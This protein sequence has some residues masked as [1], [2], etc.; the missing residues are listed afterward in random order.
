[1]KKR[2]GFLLY[3][4][5]QILDATGPA[6]VFEIGGM[7]SDIAYENTLLSVEGGPVRSSSGIVLETDKMDANQAFDTLIVVGS[8]YYRDYFKGEAIA[9]Y[10]RRQAPRTRR[11]CSVCTGAFFLARAG[12][13]SGRRVTTHWQD[14]DHLREHAHDTEVERDVVYVRDGQIWTSGGITAGIDMSLALLAEDTDETISRGVAQT[15]VLYYHRPGGEKQLSSLV[16]LGSGSDRFSLLLGW[17]RANLSTEL[18]I[19]T[20]AAHAGMSPRNFSRS[21]KTETGMSPA[22]AVE[23]LRVEAARERILNA[24]MSIEAIAAETG[25]ADPER[26]RRAFNRIYGMSP[27]QMRHSFS[28]PKRRFD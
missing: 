20:L 1:M 15:M 11:L 18:S 7:M 2:I 9:E 17:I 4:E 13:L 3:P 27:Q 22:K 12:I 23:T 6:T 5:F 24:H 14:I 25:F 10:L 8:A 21:F 26:L 16:Q 19:E 28:N